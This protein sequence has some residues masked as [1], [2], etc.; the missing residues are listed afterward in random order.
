MTHQGFVF[1]LKVG[2]NGTN[3]RFGREKGRREDFMKGVVKP[4]RYSTGVVFYSVEIFLY[5]LANKV[6]EFRVHTVEVSTILRGFR[7]F[8]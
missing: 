5:V 8:S 4:I 2:E 1:V 3:P 7:T 6:K